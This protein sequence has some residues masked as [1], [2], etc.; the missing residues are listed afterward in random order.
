MNHRT[1]AKPSR[2]NKFNTGVAPNIRFTNEENRPFSIADSEIQKVSD[3]GGNGLIKDIS[4][5]SLGTAYDHTMPNLES[6]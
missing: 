2:N 1:I 4:T 5:I 3:F 6:G